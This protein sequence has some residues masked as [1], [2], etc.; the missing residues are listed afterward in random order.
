MAPR[1]GL[2]LFSFLYQED[3]PNVV[4]S[5]GKT[6]CPGPAMAEVRHYTGRVCLERPNMGGKVSTFSFF[7]FLSFLFSFFFPSL[8]ITALLQDRSGV[9][10][11]GAGVCAD[12]FVGGCA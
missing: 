3:R 4:V 2:F 12:R 7:L 5:E 6:K 11:F 8:P 1:V 10:G 9:V